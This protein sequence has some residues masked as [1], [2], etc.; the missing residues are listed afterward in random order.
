MS[1]S[2][3]IL[4][5]LAVILC[6][7]LS[8]Q[9]PP[10]NEA[11]TENPV[12][13]VKVKRS[14]KPN[15][16]RFGTNIARIGRTVFDGGYESWGIMADM[17]LHKFLVEIS[18]GQESTN[19]TK[20]DF[21]YSMNG[22]FLRFGVDGNFVKVP[23]NGNAL[24]GGLKYVMASYDETLTFE[25]FSNFGQQ[26]T[27]LSNSDIKANWVEFNLGLRGTIIS[28]LQGG[29]YVR[30]KLFKSVKDDLN[31]ETYRIPGFGLGEYDN[32]TGFDYYL[33]WRIPFK[34]TTIGK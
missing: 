12:K 13:P 2:R 6:L 7:E 1:I 33:I 28:N 24:V 29:F 16:V 32:R 17:D 34:R 26:L 10:Q 19:N 30:F 14:W 20:G 8:A 18:Y 31:F 22:R 5:S 25:Q 27:E 23:E 9:N 21:D 11:K 15:S 3:Y 4:I